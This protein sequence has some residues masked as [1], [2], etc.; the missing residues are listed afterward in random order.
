MPLDA[1]SA[2]EVRRSHPVLADQVRTS[3]GVTFRAGGRMLYRDVP[4][5]SRRNTRIE[6]AV[7]ANPPSCAPLLRA[8]D[9]LANDGALLPADAELVDRLAMD[10][11]GLLDCFA[12][13][14]GTDTVRQWWKNR[15]QR[16]VRVVHLVYRGAI[17][18]TA[19]APAWARP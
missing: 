11:A 17:L 12:A 2:R 14:G 1:V 19:A 3:T 6:L 8:L 5:F 9:G 16:G 18:R 15:P 4:P 10:P 13:L 7:L